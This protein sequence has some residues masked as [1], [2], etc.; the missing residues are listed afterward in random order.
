MRPPLPA[1][2]IAAYWRLTR[3]ATLGAQGIVIDK[4]DHVLLVRHGY[5]D[6]WHFPGG[7]IEW[8]ETAETA[9]VREVLEETGVVVEGRPC[10]HG[11]FANFA[12][13][14]SDHIAVFVIREWR[15][16]IVPPPSLEIR[17]SRFFSRRE[18]P[19]GVAPGTARRLAELY[20]GAAPTAVW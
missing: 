10:F 5:R 4:E 3:G 12:T 14:P 11:L 8:R 20:D 2:L 1:G 7:G 16:P 15:R 9:V 13:L 6:G 18:L 17:E 19:D